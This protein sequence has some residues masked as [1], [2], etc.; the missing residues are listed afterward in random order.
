MKALS[1]VSILALTAAGTACSQ[2]SDQDAE[3]PETVVEAEAAPA[4]E[5]D[6]TGFNLGLPTQMETPTATPAGEFN[7]GLESAETT[8]TDGFNL[9]TE[10]GASSGLESIPE[11]GASIT[12]EPTEETPL[13]PV[14]DEP[15]IRL[16]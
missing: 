15:V 9:G 12:E 13:E 6:M 14:D 1:I 8:S 2:A 3:K 16:E 10:L 11:I 4:P 7:L 5:V